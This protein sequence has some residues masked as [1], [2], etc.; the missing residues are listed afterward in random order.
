VL[1]LA[2]RRPAM[3]VGAGL[4]PAMLEGPD[5]LHARRL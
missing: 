2:L 5:D 1:A 4:A 3:P